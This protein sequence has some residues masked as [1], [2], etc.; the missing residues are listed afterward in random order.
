MAVTGLQMAAVM[1]WLAGFASAVA[2]A[3]DAAVAVALAVA[4]AVTVALYRQT[5]TTGKRAIA[6][7][8]AVAPPVKPLV[9][10][11]A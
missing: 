1:T 9:L 2:M 7:A 4:S 3:V 6:E 8:K 10:A 11:A 5:C